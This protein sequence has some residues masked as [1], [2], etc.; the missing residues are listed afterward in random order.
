MNSQESSYFESWV[1]QEQIAY[2]LISLALIAMSGAAF[3]VSLATPA[4]PI[5]AEG[6]IGTI[7]IEES[8]A[9]NYFGLLLFAMPALWGLFILYWTSSREHVR[10]LTTNVLSQNIMRWRVFGLIFAALGLMQFFTDGSL[11]QRIILAPSLFIF[12]IFSI[13][14]SIKLAAFRGLGETK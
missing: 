3:A 4:N 5:I 13:F 12:G 8:P 7:V 1:R 6:T 9:L 14:R 2:W 11:L 10:A